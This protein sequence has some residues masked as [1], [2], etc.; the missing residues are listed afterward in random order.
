MVCAHN[1]PVRRSYLPSK[2]T[3]DAPAIEAT[4]EMRACP[5]CGREHLL[6][7]DDAAATCFRCWRSEHPFEGCPAARIDAA[8][9][10][11]TNPQRIREGTA[12][13]NLGLRGVD[14]PGGY[15]PLTNR[16]VSSNVKR[17]DLAARQGLETPERAVYR[18]VP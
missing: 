17:R 1:G 3:P 8:G 15:R 2:W 6:P 16:E 13:V 5:S 9:D 18:S 10:D 7:L 14:G 11:S 4:H 12:G